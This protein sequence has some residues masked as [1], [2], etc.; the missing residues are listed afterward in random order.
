MEC[1]AILYPK[2]STNM[3]LLCCFLAVVATCNTMF[4][5]CVYMHIIIVINFAYL[6][7]MHGNLV[8][9]CPLCLP[10]VYVC[11]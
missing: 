2:F 8:K 3:Q 9:Y 10:K 11:T 6:C 5:C 1:V 7:E 4:V